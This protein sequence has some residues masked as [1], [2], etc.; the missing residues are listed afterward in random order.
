M[1][2]FNGNINFYEKVYH[3]NSQS[4]PITSFIFISIRPREDSLKTV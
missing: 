3:D 2:D 1:F 4:K